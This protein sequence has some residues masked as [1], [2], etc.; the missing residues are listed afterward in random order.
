MCE[1][2]QLS[3][4]MQPRDLLR[5]RLLQ[6]PQLLEALPQML[7]LLLPAQPEESELNLDSQDVQ[8]AVKEP[9]KCQCI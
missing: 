1:I 5:P 3:F 9:W 4:G 2:L 6:Q 8:F 7:L